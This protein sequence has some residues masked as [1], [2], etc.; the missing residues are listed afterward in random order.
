MVDRSE[1]ERAFLAA[2][3][4]SERI[5][6]LG[7]LLARATGNEV[8]VVGGSAVEVLTAGR[9]ASLDIDVVTPR[10][11]AIEVIRSW[12]FEPN[13][14]VF[15]RADWEVDIDIVGPRFTGSR[16]RIRR[17]ETPY[18]PVDI[19]G[20]E[21]LI[22]KRLAEL[23]HWQTTPTWRTE[24]VRQVR[25]LLAEYGSQLDEEYLAFAAKRDDV[26]DILRD[27]RNRRDKSPVR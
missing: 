6:F 12:G 10:D 8:I 15:R 24:L 23:K 3:S 13:G 14:R 1:A 4:K 9:T 19:A 16:S 17:I 22:V 27:F 25:L 11:A 2:R 18:G 26:V 5:E 7:A 20:P 21:D